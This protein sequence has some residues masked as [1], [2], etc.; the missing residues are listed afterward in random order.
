MSPLRGSTAISAIWAWPLTRLR[1]SCASMAAAPASTASCAIRCRSASSVVVDVD[2]PRAAQEARVLVGQL[3][4]EQVDEVRGLGLHRPGHRLHRLPAGPLGGGLADVAGVG[5]GLQ[6]DVPPVARSR[7][8]RERRVP[9]RRL[10]DARNRRGLRERDVRDVLAEE[11]AR[12]FRHTVDGVRAALAEVHLVEVQLED[13]VLRGAR[14]EDDRQELFLELAPVR[15]LGRE[16]EV[17]H[18]LLGERAPADEVGPVAPDVRDD[19]ARRS[20]WG[21]CRDD[22]RSAGP[23]WRG[24]PG[25]CAS[26][27]ARATPGGVSRGWT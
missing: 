5:H 3:L 10:D 8:R 4:A 22:R 21:R 19:G 15:F 18:E 13:V 24:R 20:G 14:L 11:D 2:G 1:A 25:P 16:E 27:S 26:E 6:H 23:R 9:A 17:L 12:R 7:G